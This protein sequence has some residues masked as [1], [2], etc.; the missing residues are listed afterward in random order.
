MISA[1]ILDYNSK[2]EASH[3]EIAQSLC[4]LISE[5]LPGAE[6][7]VWHGHPVWFIDG[8]PILGY[9]LK[10]AGVEVLFWS[11]KSFATTG[12]RPVGKYQAAG[13]AIDS[14]GEV[15]KVSTFMAEAKSVQWN[16]KDLPK[17]RQLEKLTA[18]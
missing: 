7:K 8:N 5:S 1:D 18:F 12:L 6:G 3:R 17:L 14:L 11:G 2:L 10:K 16:Y 9:S 15:A 13:I 4:E